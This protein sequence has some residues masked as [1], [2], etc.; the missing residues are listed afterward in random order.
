ME[1]ITRH[2]SHEIAHIA[3]AASLAAIALT[4]CNSRGGNT[5]PKAES[6]AVPSA[7]S[8]KTPPALPTP[9]AVPKRTTTHDNPTI[10]LQRSLN[11]VLTP[12]GMPALTL[13]GNAGSQT[14]RALCAERIFSGHAAS[15]AEATVADRNQLKSHEKLSSKLPGFVISR[16]CQ[17]MG[18]NIGDRLSMIIPISTGAPAGYFQDSPQDHTTAAGNFH[19][20]QGIYGLHNSTKYPSK[21]SAGNMLFSGFFNGDEAVHGSPEMSDAVTSPISHG[22]V[23]FDVKYAPHIW[24]LMGGQKIGVQDHYV[25]LSPIPVEVL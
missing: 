17:V 11:A 21:H 19:I 14:K 22:C 18:I 25:N 20:G 24:E 15:Q 23:R 10:S 3:L 5:T 2:R 13:D 8:T 12:Y 7:T 4:G 6:S 16:T 9:S 1:N